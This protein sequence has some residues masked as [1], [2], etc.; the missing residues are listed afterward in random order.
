MLHRA[1]AF[2]SALLLSLS[3][4]TARA[5]P[6]TGIVAAAEPRAAAAGQEILRAG[7]SAAD[8]AMA[9]MLALTVTEPMSSGIGGGGFLVYHDAKTG[10]VSTIDG[11]ETAPAS[12]G[13]DRF[14]GADGKPL[15][16]MQAIPGGYSVGIPGNVALMAET[17]KRW[18]KL[19]W[20]RLFEP[21]IRLAE[22]GYTLLP[23]NEPGPYSV[24]RT[25]AFRLKQAERLWA[26]FP[27]A[28]AI[29]WKDGRP[30]TSGETVKNPVLAATLREIAAK[31]P[32][33]FYKGDIAR[34]IS[35]AIAASKRNPTVMSAADL[36]GYRAK[37]RAAICGVYRGYRI[38]GMGPPS[39]GAITDLMILSML[40]RFD[41]KA[42]GKDSPVAW[43]LI[44][45]A[46]RL[47][48]ADRDAWLGDTDFVAAPVAGLLDP[49]YL[50]A[51][52]KLISPDRTL[53][54]YRPGTPPGAGPLAMTQAPAE[55][56]TTHFVAIDRQ[57]NIASM[58]STV[59]GPFG[60][61]L[62]AGGFFLNNELTDFNEQPRENGRLVPNH[63]EP[64]KRPLSS[65]SP[66]IVYGPDGRPAMALG[67]AGGRTII[68]H[69]LKALVGT[70]DWGLPAADAIALP[71]LFFN[72]PALTVER[73]SPLEAMIP[74][75]ARLGETAVAGE[76]PSKLTILQRTPAGWVGAADPRSPGVA[77]S[78]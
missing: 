66:M 31:G 42:L 52:S 20:A 50:A 15:P 65:M 14:L 19:T 51:R 26:D 22:Q 9:I 73:G 46:M 71:N 12:A 10:R 23:D 58:T 64:G 68:M 61:S 11:R 36:A 72:G 13:P 32:D 70:I 30:L 2:L 69:G 56:G 75:L 78:Q 25:L 5:V 16:Y 76:L 38:C 18:G 28:R 48:Y 53:G 41:L 29:Y 60:S 27:E 47:A 62:V 77:L 43:H 3:P 7:G 6:A 67:S 8:A 39:S 4:A 35:A 44:G 74:A 34:K 49:A 17:H 59:E 57:G 54:E 21:A 63:V 33:A 40:E 1:I 45:E 55:Q 37:P 24:Q